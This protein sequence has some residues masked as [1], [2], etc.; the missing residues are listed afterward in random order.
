MRFIRYY[1]VF[2][3]GTLSDFIIKVISI[4]MWEK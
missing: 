1:R 4:R 3:Q 2:C